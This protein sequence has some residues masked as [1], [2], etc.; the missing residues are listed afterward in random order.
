MGAERSWPFPK[1]EIRKPGARQTPVTLDTWHL[2]LTPLTPGTLSHLPGFFDVRQAL[3]AE[4]GIVQPGIIPAHFHQPGVAAFLDDP[5]V[6]D[7]HNPVRG[8]DRRKAVRDQ[9]AG[10]A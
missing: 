3:V 2:T 8:F 9:N 6:V 7:D 1:N 4:V 5:P 10:C